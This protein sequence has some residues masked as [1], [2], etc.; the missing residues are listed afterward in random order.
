[1]GLRGTGKSV[2]VKRVLRGFA[3]HLVYDPLKEHG[4]EFNVYNPRHVAESPAA[5]AELDAVIRKWV[6]P[7]PDVRKVDLFAIDEANRYAPPRSRLGPA[8][9]NV[10]DFQRHAGLGVMYVARRPVTLN[11]DL[12]ELA[13]YLMVFRLRGKN[14]LDYLETISM[15]LKD[16]VLSLP[17]YSFVLVG[18][19][20]SFT[21]C[22]PV[23][24]N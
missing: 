7:K 23:P 14:D 13:D 15:G 4:G 21:L 20:R 1:V 17:L 5:K 9:Q 10:N 11:T 3:S 22:N 16:A 6:M 12:M 18:P 24:L 2:L 19:D 8:L